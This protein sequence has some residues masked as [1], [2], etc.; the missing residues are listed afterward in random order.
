[1]EAVKLASTLR[2]SGCSVVSAFGDKRLK[3]QLR[4]ADLSG[5]HR[6]VIIGES[7]VESGTVVVKDMHEGGQRTVRVEDV[8]DVL[9]GS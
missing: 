2:R 5:A 8:V 6:A 9:K 7:E 1:M 3:A 4:H